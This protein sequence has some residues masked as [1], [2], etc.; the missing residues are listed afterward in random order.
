[1][2]M[3]G[4]E[5]GDPRMKSNLAKFD[6]VRTQTKKKLRLACVLSPSAVTCV[7]HCEGLSKC[8]TSKLHVLKDRLNPAQSW[9]QNLEY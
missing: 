3:T 7:R 8:L 9:E 2:A 4:S 6:K 1:M 5:E